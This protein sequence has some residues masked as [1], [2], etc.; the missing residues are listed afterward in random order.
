MSR[1]VLDERAG[2]TQ[3][4]A[5]VLGV[6]MILGMT[7]SPLIA[8]WEEVETWSGTV[9]NR[10]VEDQALD[11]QVVVTFDRWLSGDC[12]AQ[13]KVPPLSLVTMEI[14]AEVSSQVE[15]AILA[16][17]F[18]SDWTVVDVSIF[19]NMFQKSL[20]HFP[21]YKPPKSPEIEFQ[22]K[23]WRKIGATNGK[24]Y[25][26]SREGAPFGQLDQSNQPMP[27]YGAPLPENSR[28]LKRLEL[29]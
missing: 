15:N 3:R 12:V 20:K 19:L 6:L 16:D 14:T 27:S 25:S 4:A 8:Q 11:N 2:I 22:L 17:Y 26:S 28:L 18:P 13:H 5:A 10:M 9:E 21:S 7:A 1:R 24:A 29:F 23:K